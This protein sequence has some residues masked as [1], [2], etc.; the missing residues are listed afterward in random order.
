MNS[1]IK[2]PPT[3][4]QTISEAD[5]AA[6][7]DRAKDFRKLALKTIPS[8]SKEELEVLDKEVTASGE[9]I[10]TFLKTMEQKMNVKILMLKE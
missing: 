9:D 1:K 10:E 6:M 2:S 7:E 5:L 4:K 8:L 3:N